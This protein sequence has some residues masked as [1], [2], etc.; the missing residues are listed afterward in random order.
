[1]NLRNID[2]QKDMA[3]LY[4]RHRERAA[5]RGESYGAHLPGIEGNNQEHERGK[6]GDPSGI[7]RL[8]QN[9]RVRDVSIARFQTGDPQ[10]GLHHLDIFVNLLEMDLATGT[11]E[12]VLVDGGAFLV[13]K[14]THGVSF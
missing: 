7:G 2:L 9:S 14:S 6:A 8:P 1:M 5:L 13:G 10:G 3:R 12:Q 11:K 4:V